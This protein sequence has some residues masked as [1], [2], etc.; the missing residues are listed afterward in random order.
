MPG[1]VG[2]SPDSGGGSTPTREEIFSSEVRGF[3]A[4]TR[5]K[6]REERGNQRQT[7]DSKRPVSIH[8]LFMTLFLLLW[9]AML[10]ALAICLGSWKAW[11]KPWLQVK[12]PARPR[13]VRPAAR[14]GSVSVVI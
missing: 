7:A 3:K 1:S 9:L 5:G 13:R 4:K 6:R 12:R 14:M 11:L 10:G 8:V 2:E